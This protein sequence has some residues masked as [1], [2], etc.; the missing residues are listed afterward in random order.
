MN[1]LWATIPQFWKG[2]LSSITGALILTGLAFAL[3]I[4]SSSVREWMR[5][6]RFA[7]QA[8]REQLVA[9]NVG[10]RIEANLQILFNVLKWLILGGLFWVIPDAIYFLFR[11]DL[12]FLA[13]VFSAVSI[14]IALRWALVYQRPRVPAHDELRDMVISSVFRLFFN[15]PHQSKPITFEPDG[16]VGA[17]RNSNEHSWRIQNSELELV[18]QDGVV[19]SRFAYDPRTATFFHTNATDTHSIRNQYIVTVQPRDMANQAL[20]GT[21]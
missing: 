3:R 19:H 8:I 17:G 9:Q 7:I 12:V 6:R 18:Q 11:I 16:S 20:H 13:R 14:V 15:P 1:D 10:T 21:Q 2:V 5:N 4:A